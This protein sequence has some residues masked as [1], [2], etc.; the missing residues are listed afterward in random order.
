MVENV[1]R[2]AVGVIQNVQG[3]VFIARRAA[4]AH[5]GGLWEFPGGKVEAGETTPQALVRE[6]REELAIEVQACEPL[7][8]IRHRYPD[9]S[10]LLDVYRVSAFSG[11]ARGNEGQPVRWVAPAQLENFAFP[12][13]NIPIINAIRLPSCCAISA[14]WQNLPDFL[15]RTQ[16]AMHAGAGMLIVR[17]NPLDERYAAVLSQLAAQ[18]WASSLCVQLNTSPEL[19]AGLQPYFPAAGLHLNRHQLRA[20]HARQQPVRPV[21]ASVLLG[22]SCHNLEE[23][24][25][26]AQLGVDYALLSP[27]LA[28]AS[29]PQVEPLGW[30][31]FASWV[32]TVN[33]PVY[34]LGGVST[35]QVAQARTAGAQG[36]AALSAFW[37]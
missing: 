26:A 25:W 12:A 6:L 8:Q 36:I 21:A 2:V 19:F 14:A 20:S 18:P 34:A 33:F 35:E 7:I 9:K 16:A 23:L 3:E 27:V 15:R 10:V 30:P 11:D 32:E 5:Q 28:T 22:A 31:V 13:A 17:D 37:P 1:I 24:Q 4:D 29:H